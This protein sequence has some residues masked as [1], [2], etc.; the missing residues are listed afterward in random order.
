MCEPVSIISGLGAAATAVGGFQSQNEQTRV[1]NQQIA[2]RYNR[3]RVNYELGNLQKLAIQGT[4]EIDSDIN[5]DAIAFSA[6]NAIANSFL[7]EAETN[8]R[9]EERLQ[10]IELAALKGTGK[11]D[12]GGRSRSYGKNIE[13]K[14]GQAIGSLMGQRSRLGVA[15]FSQRREIIN[16]AQKD[17]IAEWRRVNL[18]AGHSGPGP[19]KPTFMK[20]PSKLALGLQLAGAAGTAFAPA[21]KGSPGLSGSQGALTEWNTDMAIDAPPIPYID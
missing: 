21:F 9:L 20:G 15:G 13:L 10:S 4:K 12:E 16:K 19:A 3:D 2:D 17:R 11:A 7:S 8:R 14:S 6:S 5:Q 1:Q 18:G